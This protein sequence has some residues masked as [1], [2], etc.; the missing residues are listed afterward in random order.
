MPHTINYYQVREHGHALK[1]CQKQCF[2]YH[3]G[4]RPLPELHPGPQSF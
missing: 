1:Q 3:D 2:D 4:T